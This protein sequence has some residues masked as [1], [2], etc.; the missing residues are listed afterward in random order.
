MNHTFSLFTNLSIHV[1]SFIYLFIYILYVCPFASFEKSCLFGVALSF[2][3]ICLILFLSSQF[4]Y[5]FGNNFCYVNAIH[6]NSITAHSHSSSRRFM[7]GG[8]SVVVVIL[9]PSV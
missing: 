8:G 1:Y 6:S 2:Y 3:G 7:R 5:I 9:S 4:F